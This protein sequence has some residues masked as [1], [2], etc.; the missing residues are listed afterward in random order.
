[1]IK[2]SIA[3]ASLNALPSAFVVWRGFEESAIKASHMGFDGIELAL[4]DTNEISPEELHKL[5]RKNNL[6]V[7]CIST[8]QIYADTGLM[9][10]EPDDH[11]RKLLSIRFQNI[12]D[13]A[14]DFGKMVNIGRVRGQLGSEPEEAIIRCIEMIERLSEYAYKKDVKLVIEPINRYETD[15]INSLSQAEKFIKS[16]DL[17]N[18]GLMPDVFHMN[19]EDRFIG[20]ELEKYSSLIK[21]IHIADSN[22]HAP[23]WGHIDFDDIFEH[24]KAV[25]YSG[26]LSVEILPIP[27]PDEA[28]L[29]SISFL[30]PYIIDYNQA[31][32]LKKA[33][34]E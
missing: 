5:L 4:K 29:Q 19:I 15:F 16:I 22:R 23:G 7:S 20:K 27:N 24:L 12:I 11:K 21:Y 26:W 1:M 17:Q 33:K 8:G 14:A 2:L 3:I 10:T 18:I 25:E 28:A 13:L 31:L 6:V 30:K 32:Y 34:Y 9:F